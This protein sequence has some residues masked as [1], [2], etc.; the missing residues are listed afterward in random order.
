MIHK[1]TPAPKDKSIPMERSSQRLVRQALYTW[2]RK[3]SVVKVP[4]TNPR[5]VIDCIYNPHFP[6]YSH[7]ISSHISIVSDFALDRSA[8]GRNLRQ[9]RSAT[10]VGI[11]GRRVAERARL[12]E[13]ISRY[14][15]LRPHARSPAAVERAPPPRGLALG[16][17]ERGMDARPLQ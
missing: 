16:S 7:E 17:A 5:N 2:G 11:R 8:A 12:G 10:I 13:Q 4:A 6:R 9:Q 3:E 1:Q 14:P 15:R